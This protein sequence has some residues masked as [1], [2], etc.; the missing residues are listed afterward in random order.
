M[1][2]RL[3]LSF[4]SLFSLSLFLIEDAWFLPSSSRKLFQEA[5]RI[6]AFALFFIRRPVVEL[7]CPWV[8]PVRYE[9][10]YRWYG[11]V[12]G[13][14]LP[15]MTTLSTVFLLRITSRDLFPSLH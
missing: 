6:F 14:P 1:I 5:M 11:V 13:Q 8:S 15:N 12:Y 9:A 2:P 3:S 4:L 10:G 7:R